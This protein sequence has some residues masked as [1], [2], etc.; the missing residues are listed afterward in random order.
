MTRHAQALFAILF[1]LF[2]LF[3]V[4]IWDWSAREVIYLYWVENVLIGLAQVVK[5]LTVREPNPDAPTPL[6]AKLPISGFFCI[7]YGMFCFVHGIFVISLT[8]DT[9]LS[10]ETVKE[11]PNPFL[12][13]SYLSGAALLAVGSNAVMQI[14][15]VTR[16]HFIEGG[17][18]RS[19]LNT[20]MN[21][22][23]KHIIVIH[24]A[25]IAAAFFTQK[26]QSA[27]PLLGLIVIGKLLLDLKSIYRPK[28]ASTPEPQSAPFQRRR[29][30]RH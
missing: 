23:Y 19:T 29:R 12:I 2:P 26:Y 22:P 1:A 10:A 4:W 3:G 25:I 21:E 9:T 7:H 27:L 30:K 17:R 13:T 24:I 5:L 16:E 11:F 15:R 18:D 14:I 8:Q 20:L 6:F 28:K